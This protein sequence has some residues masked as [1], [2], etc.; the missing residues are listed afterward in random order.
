LGIGAWLVCSVVA[1]AE[2]KP[3]S[4][5]SDHAVLQTGMDVPVWGTASPGEKVTVSINGISASTAAASD[6]SWTVK[7]KKLKT[8]GP[9]EMT[10]AGSNTI[11]VHDVL[12]GEV[13]LGSGQSNMVFTLSK[14]NTSWAG[15]NDEAGV[16]AEAND[17][18]VRMFTGKATK[19]YEP[20][21]DI[22]GE[23]KV[24]TPENAGD[25][26]AVGY[27]FARGLRQRL[28]VPVGIVLEAYGGST[29]EAWL[30]R[31]VVAN[32][33]LLKPRLEAFDARAAYYRAHQDATNADAP[34]APVTINGRALP[35][36][37]PML[38][39]VEDQHQPTVLYNG[40]LAPV[41]PYAIR[42]ILWYQGESIV[43]GRQGVEVYPHTM[44][45][46]VKTWRARWGNGDLPFYFVQLAA[47]NNVS[48]NPVVREAQSQLLKLP[49]TA[50][51]VTIDIG[52]ETN[53]H[54]KNKAPVGER[55]MDIALAKSYG[56]KIEYSG[57][58]YESMKIEGGKV[59]LKFSHASGL[60]AKGG[61]PA[62]FEIAG[63]DER[64]VPAEA[65]IEG[66]AV[67]VSSGDVPVPVAVRYAWKNYP[68]DANL[69]NSAGLPAAPFRTDSWDAL[70]RVA[71]GF[72]A[73]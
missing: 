15:V 14:K 60:M 33:P 24:C 4:L 50:M 2:V 18:Q 69:Y 47:L 41:L 57:P 31:E 22:L 49:H 65:T 71:E 29:A 32:D 63:V 61:K 21:K 30:P 40:M 72:T 12:V 68:R 28:K 19:T 73:K 8:G 20:Q 13:W 16:I 46:L 44:E 1:G 58:V 10:I 3:A 55:L 56:Q 23:W 39:P 9:F 59:K 54:P 62:E 42:G 70:T 51:A 53:V 35:A 64:F 36:N 5:F 7:L 25:F 26:S 38:D 27:Y 43:G 67:V 6:G 48:N 66:D 45:T 37:K 11:T 34:P 52:D 17:P